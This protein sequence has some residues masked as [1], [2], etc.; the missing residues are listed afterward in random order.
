M[1][2]MERFN[3][4]LKEAEYKFAKNN[5]RIFI[6]GVPLS[7]KST[8]S[9]LVARNI[10]DCT[11]QNMDI[12][13]LTA[14]MVE[15]Q[16]PVE[17]RSLFVNYGSCDS[18]KA[19]GDGTFSPESLIEGF[20]LYSE[21]VSDSLSFILP[22]LEA[23]GAKDVLF[24]GVQTTPDIVKRHMNDSTILIVL[25]SS[26][27]RLRKNATKM[28]GDEQWLLDRY[29]PDKLILLQKEILRQA[30]DFPKDKL[31]IVDNSGKISGSAHKIMD[32]LLFSGMI[33]LK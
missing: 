8:I 21:I 32:F 4:D 2:G 15:E 1:F 5:S 18:Y 24:D 23:Q 20:K 27:S 10:S 9:P 25:T 16:K 13:R 19:I 28:F 31:L 14:Q 33:K 29:S 7:G 30:K 6:T 11:W 22:K 26:E 17:L 3:G 12:L